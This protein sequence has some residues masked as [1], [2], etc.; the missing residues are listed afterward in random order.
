M[1]CRRMDLSWPILCILVCLF[2]LSVKLPKGWERIARDEPLVAVRLPASPPRLAK[3][4]APP[5]IKE[6]TLALDEG[7][8]RA[9]P[10]AR[11]ASRPI[12]EVKSQ[13]P[14]EPALI[15][16]TPEPVPVDKPVQTQ[17]TKTEAVAQPAMIS[18]I[19][20]PASGTAVAEKPLHEDKVAEGLPSDSDEEVAAEPPIQDMVTDEP[21]PKGQAAEAMAVDRKPE[22]E[23]SSSIKLVPLPASDHMVGKAEVG[24]EIPRVARSTSSPSSLAP[25]LE[26]KAEARSDFAYPDTGLPSLKS[27]SPEPDPAAVAE[28]QQPSRQKPEKVVQKQPR[29]EGPTWQE[30]EALLVRL[31]RLASHEATRGWASESAKWTRKLGPAL[32]SGSEETASI[33]ARLEQLGTEAPTLVATVRDK[34]LAQDLSRAGHALGRRVGVWKQ[35]HAMGGM[36]AL[37][38]QAPAVDP[39]S[40]SVCLAEIDSLTK[41]SDEGNAWRKYLLVDALREWSARRKPV[42]DRLPRELSYQLLK[43]LRQTAMSPRQ[44]QLL[45]S[46]PFASLHKEVVLHAA[47]SVDS[48]RLLRHLERYERSGLPSDGRLLAEDCQYLS[49]GS[50]GAC[51]QLAS[52]VEM[53][54]RNANLRLAVSEDLL[55]RLIPKSEPEYGL[56]NDTVLGV[57]VR[58]KSLMA[59]EVAVRLLPDPQR[60]LLALEVTGEVASLTASTAGPATFLSDS[61]SMYTA[62]KPLEVNLRGISL[63]PTEVDVQ[64][65]TRLRRIRTDFDRVPLVGSL[66]RGVAKSQHDQNKPAAEAEVRQKIA[67][68][69][70]ER[71]DNEAST[72]IAQAAQQLNQKVLGPMDALLLDPTLIAAETTSQ[73]FIMR[74]RLAGTDQLGS[75]TPRPQAPADSLASV[76]VHETA[77]NNVI[78]RL[79]LDGQTFTLPE[80]GRHLAQRLNRPAKECDPD[81]EDV[82]ITFACQDAIHVRCVGGRLELTLAVAKLSKGARRWKDFQVRTYYRPEVKGRAITLARDGIVQL[83]GPRL[84]TGSQIALRGVFSKVFS[85]K[86]PWNV[87]PEEFENNPKLA[88]LA[89]TQFTIDD[90]WVGVALGPQRAVTARPALLRR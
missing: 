2:I 56:V 52:R 19:A 11:F 15:T 18:D 72:R 34:S 27:I 70:Q 89:F 50:N 83:I 23:V 22:G 35:I 85:Q 48:T 62:R 86:T 77:L 30:P 46:G 13:L 60:V 32:S 33:L 51:Q 79:E 67:S 63:W 1:F 21:A 20:K 71:I 90:G 42:E 5:E 41:D 84:N 26:P 73:R 40:I 45:A 9:E 65:S 75:H 80:L 43:R 76:Q 3:L 24:P 6:P 10:A 39:K 61:E 16:P 87:T 8:R 14:V 25:M 4:P 82:K 57:P 69:A 88:G 12:D 37:S 7:F 74:V 81:Q 17:T 68:Q 47:E 53:H 44:R 55:N 31:D 59:N 28:P 66:V 29:S 49:L 54:Y 64:N 38:V 36:A 58:G 78:Q